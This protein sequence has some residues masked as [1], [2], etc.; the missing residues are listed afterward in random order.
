M[1]ADGIR[2]APRPALIRALWAVVALL[3][4]LGVFAAAGRTVFLDDF[5]ARAEP[6]RLWNM[7]A[8]GRDDPRALQRPAVVARMDGTFA[9]HPKLTLLHVVPGGLFLLFAPLQFVSRL[10]VRHP[11]LHR[12]SG[13]ILLLLLIAS[14]LPG[15]FFGLLMP[16]GGLGEAVAIALFGVTLLIAIVVAVVAIR[17]GQIARHREWMIRVFAFAIAISTIR[18]AFGVIDAALTPS[19]YPPP[20]Q[21]VLS[22]W[23]GWIVT[24]AAAEAWIR[25]TRGRVNVALPNKISHGHQYR[26]VGK[27]SAAR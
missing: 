24:L 16:F 19:G 25:Y 8:L 10:R 2:S 3:V 26:T 1:S 4:A 23:A 21:F 7:T 5:I 12:W 17:R 6:V 22:V 11:A 13:R 27:Y 15:L 18:I 14:A 20:D 9:S